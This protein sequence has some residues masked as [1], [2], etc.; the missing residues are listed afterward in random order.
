MSKTV[1]DNEN[2]IDRTPNTDKRAAN[3]KPSMFKV[4]FLNDD[5]TTMQFVIEML[6]KH[7]NHTYDDAHSIMLQVHRKGIGVAGVY[8]LDVAETKAMVVIEEAR[9]NK[10]PLQTAV[11]QV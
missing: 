7:F 11:D 4:L 1:Q 8:Q 2:V 10:F 9:L 5:F 6:E 3:R